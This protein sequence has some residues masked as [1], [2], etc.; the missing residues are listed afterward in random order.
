MPYASAEREEQFT[1][2]RRSGAKE[3]RP[4]LA[5]ARGLGEEQST[6]YSREYDNERKGNL[7][8]R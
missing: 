1:P 7:R 8:R 3:P 4:C 5:Q 2:L 6:L